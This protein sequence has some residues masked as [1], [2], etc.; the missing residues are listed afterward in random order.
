M[1]MFLE[2]AAAVVEVTEFSFRSVNED[3]TLRSEGEIIGE[4]SGKAVPAPTIRPEH[5]V[6]RDLRYPT[7]SVCGTA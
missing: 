6:V 2:T 5:R 7:R 3:A 1:M 4:D